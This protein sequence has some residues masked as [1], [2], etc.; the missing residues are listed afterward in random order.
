M[1]QKRSTTYK[2]SWQP[3]AA[4]FHKNVYFADSQKEKLV[5]SDLKSEALRLL[6]KE[7][8]VILDGGNYIKG[9]QQQNF[10]YIF[11]TLPGFIRLSL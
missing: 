7:S 3:Q 2:L 6:D 11:L 9:K 5:R 4:G 8:V 10:C 1:H